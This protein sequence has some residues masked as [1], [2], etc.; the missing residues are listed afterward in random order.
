VSLFTASITTVDSLLPL[1]AHVQRQLVA[2]AHS[3][4]LTRRNTSHNIKIKMAASIARCAATRTARP[5]AGG[6][7][8]SVPALPVP[9]APRRAGL[10]VRAAT[11][12]DKPAIAQVILLLQPR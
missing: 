9:R 5:A 3:Q 1:N 4:R 6:R 12:G 11:Q 8:C 2:A 10:T 7:R